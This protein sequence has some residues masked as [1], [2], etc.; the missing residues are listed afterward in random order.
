MGRVPTKI[1]GF[2]KLVQG[3]FI[4]SSVNLITGGCGT[5]KTLF[6]L[7][8]LVNQIH[9]G[10][11]CLFVTFEESLQGLVDDAQEFGWDL[12]AY[13]KNKQCSFIAFEP[14]SSPTTLEHLTQLIK[15]RKIEI[16]VIDSIS[17]MAMVFENNYYKMR[18]ELYNL[19]NLLRSLNCTSLFTSEVAGDAPL[20]ISGG[21]KLSRDGVIEFIADSVITMHNSGIGGE[22]DRAIRVLKMRRTEHIKGPQPLR[23]TAKGIR[24]EKAQF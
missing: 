10:K 11:R 12:E 6:S 17:V 3:G 14:V 5:G 24:V 16:V 4:K 15:K 19:C 7:H 20:D 2:D 13:E 18:K 21:G 9:E 1:P 23:I 8:F 22:S